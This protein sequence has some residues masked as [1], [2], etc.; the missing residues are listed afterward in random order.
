[1]PPEVEL[2]T[3][4]NKSG[5]HSSPVFSQDTVVVEN[6]GY[7]ESVA[8]LAQEAAEHRAAAEAHRAAAE[9]LNSK[10]SFGRLAITGGVGLALGVGA[11]IGIGYWIF[12][13]PAV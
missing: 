13:P 5:I 6:Q 10:S 12:T 11:G 7:A 8:F 3:K 9:A 1:M 2:T 4:S